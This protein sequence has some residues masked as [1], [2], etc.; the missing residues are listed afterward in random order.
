M[1]VL[2][3]TAAELIIG[4]VVGPLVVGR[5]VSPM[6]RMRVEMLLHLSSF[7][8][9]GVVFG[10]MT[11]GVR[12]AEPAVAAMVSVWLTFLMSFFLP[13]NFVHFSTDKVL[14]SGGIACVLALFGTYSA[15]KWLGHFK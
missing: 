2:V 8:G 12:L 11:P 15:E 5:F 9:G 7:L 13:H 14:V 10:F 1:G 3:F 4:L 6:L